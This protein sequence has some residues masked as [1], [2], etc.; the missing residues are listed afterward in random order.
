MMLAVILLLSLLPIAS[1]AET[2]AAGS[3]FTYTKA[4]HWGKESDIWSW[5]W[6]LADSEDFQNMT[7]TT[8]EGQG[9]CYVA[10]WEKYPYCA[11]RSGGNNVH[12]NEKADAARVFTAPATGWVT[13]SATVN[14]TNEYTV[15]S[16]KSP[17]SFRILLETTTVYPTEG[18]YLILTSTE[19]KVITTKVYVK[20]GEKL[21]FVIGAMDNQTADATNLQTTV[22]YDTVE[23][24]P[25]EI[26]RV[27]ESFTYKPTSATWGTEDPHWYWEWTPASKAIFSPMTYQYVEKYSK[28]MYASDWETN[29]Y[30]YVD[31]LGVKVHPAA[32]VDTVKT[33]VVPYTGTVNLNTVVSRYNN[34]SEVS[35]SEANGTSLRILVNTTQVYPLYSSYLTL[36]SKTAKN[37]NVSLPVT[38]GDKIRII[39]GGIGQV[40]SD[41]VEMYNT[42]TYTDVSKPEICVSDGE[43]FA[44]TEA[45]W[46]NGELGN[47]S[48]EYRDQDDTF[49]PMTYQYVEHYGRYMYATDWTNHAYNCADQLGVKLHPA[50]TCDA[51]KTY[52]VPHDG[53]IRLYT[54]VMRYT[55]YV[56]E[57]SKTPTSLRIYKNNEQIW[58]TNGSQK[59]ITSVEELAFNVYAD[60]RAGDKIR[61]VVGSMDNTTND[62]IKMYNTVTYRA[63]GTRELA[64]VMDQYNQRIDVIDLQGDNLDSAETAWSWKPTTALGFSS[65]TTFNSPTDAKLRYSKSLKKYVVAVCSSRG[66]MGVVDFATGKNLW[67]VSVTDESN[68]H[69]IEYLPNG[70]VAVA[71][72]IGGWIRIYTASQG[73]SST[74]YTQANL[75]GAHGVHWDDDRKILWCLGT[76]EITAYQIGGTAAKPTLKELTQYHVP[77]TEDIRSGHDLS[78]VYGNKD[79]LWISAKTVYQFDIPSKSFVMAYDEEA[80]VDHNSV[81]GI[82]N[83]S[84]SDTIVMVYPN[85]TYLTHDSDRIFVSMLKDGDFYGIT[86]TH[87]TGAYYKVRS[88]ISAYTDDTHRAHREETVPGKE[89]T[90]TAT[91][92]TDGTKCSVCGITMTAQTVIPAKGHSYVYTPKDGETHTVTCT[93]C[94]LS[95]EEVHSYTQGT[96]LC[97]Q[98]EV[99]EPIQESTWKLGHT[100][101]LASDISVNLAVSKSL[102]EGFDM[103][104][105]YVLAELDTYEGNT[106]TGTKTLKL[107]PTE[108]GNYYYFTLTGLTAVHMNDR[109]CSV[110]YGTKDGQIYFSATDD[111]SVADYAYSQLNKANM[112]ISLKTL[113]A[114]LLRYGA[115]A[116]AFKSYRT[117]HLADSAMTDSHKAFLSDIDTVAFGNTNTV[118]N[119]LP[120]GSVTWAGKALELNS[121]VTLKFIFNPTNYDGDVDDL[122][123][124]LTYTAISGET[125]TVSLENAELY[126]PERNYYA[127]SFDGLLAAELR[128]VVSVQVHAGDTPVSA[129]LQYSAD[130]YGN[131]KTGTLGELCKALLAYSDSAKTYFAG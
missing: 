44:V 40:T 20:Q 105:V 101:N 76:E 93:A 77:F 118:L 119:D 13:V 19:P 18:D 38:A 8:V 43:T 27:G 22:T 2:V 60:V 57:G 127:F 71:A 86:H 10:D 117:D 112:P 48:F 111:Y 68:P 11:A 33:F 131:N 73:K 72:S 62:G 78:P 98:T 115:K 106:K 109:I 107:L 24:T 128:T 52:T 120:D 88:W 3:S 65:L 67:Q 58:P 41:A 1:G 108:Q 25:A 97:G 63:V 23:E 89:A 99:K 37:F 124:R 36:D 29:P 129:T 69:S 53:R 90:C 110:L 87:P 84:D 46:A 130:T 39:I 75:Q 50:K 66:F 74:T 5:E 83:F 121:K 6:A 64:A 45:Q 96:C 55:E 95:Q 70:N 28:Y 94:T 21:R 85:G 82:S 113:C 80:V 51:V 32:N 14:R 7:F 100:L 126:N 15:P 16:S 9:E 114:D 56:A 31:S 4:D 35:N 61:F 125:K 42:V 122:T 104:M 26:L 79:R 123:L 12:P 34:L 49:G 103:D 116:Q 92:L 102:L 54:R 81:K 47:W 17:T 59:E 91:G 30:N